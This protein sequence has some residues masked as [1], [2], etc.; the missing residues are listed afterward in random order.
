MKY[1]CYWILIVCCVCWVVCFLGILIM[2]CFVVVF[3]GWLI[4]GSVVDRMILLFMWGIV[5]FLV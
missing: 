4:V 2:L 5:L 1:G 3:E